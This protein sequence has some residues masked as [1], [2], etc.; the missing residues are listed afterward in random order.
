M[1]EIIKDNYTDSITNFDEVSQMIDE[2]CDMGD[3]ERIRE[4]LHVANE[5]ILEQALELDEM[6][7]RLQKI[8]GD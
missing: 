6:K 3:I 1:S 7:K 2:L 5:E 4:A 8:N